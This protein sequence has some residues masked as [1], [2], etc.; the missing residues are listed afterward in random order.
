[1]LGTLCCSL[2]KIISRS[3]GIN[4][5]VFKITIC[6]FSRSMSE[7]RWRSSLTCPVMNRASTLSLDSQVIALVGQ[8]LP[9]CTTGRHGVTSVPVTLRIKFCLASSSSRLTLIP[10]PKM[11]I[12]RTQSHPSRGTLVC[13]YGKVNN[14]LLRIPC[15]SVVLFLHVL[16]QFLR[17]AARSCRSRVVRD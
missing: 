3:F 7:K 12:H 17:P 2:A 10:L 6:G 14:M 4:V 11:S 8:I 1:M 9:F 15:R 16:Y 13:W 5:Q